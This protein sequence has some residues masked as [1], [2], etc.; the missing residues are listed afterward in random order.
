VLLWRVSV[1]DT[2]TGS[3]IGKDGSRHRRFDFASQSFPQASV[4]WLG[5]IP[6]NWA[7]THRRRV[8]RQS[9]GR[10][11]G[12]WTVADLVYRP[13]RVATVGVAPAHLTAVLQRLLADLS[14]HHRNQS[15]PTRLR[16]FRVS[17]SAQAELCDQCCLSVCM[18]VCHSILLAG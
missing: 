13:R 14:Q 7:G 1:A 8:G 6:G 11:S 4:A 15:L 5:A 16:N 17:I 3:R 12:R 10:R 18:S 2:Q 9:D